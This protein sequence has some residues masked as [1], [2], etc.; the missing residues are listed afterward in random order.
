MA[1]KMLVVTGAGHGIGAMISRCAAKEGYSVSLWDKDLAAAQSVANSIGGTASAVDVDV[2]DEDSV[3]AAFLS[4]PAVPD[5]VVSN[6]GIVRFGPLLQLA[7]SDWEQALRVNLT[8]AFLVGRAAARVMAERA[9]GVIVNIASIN[10]VSAAPFAGG[11]SASKAGIIML[12]QQMA[13]EWAS[14][15][16]RV[17]AVAPGL[18]D[19]G[20]SEPIYED[21]EVRRLR[22]SKVP[23]DRLGSAED[24]AAAVLFLTG[25]T[26]SYI[27]GQTLVVDGGITIAAL[28]QL[29]RPASIDSVGT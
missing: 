18:I 27:T 5:A 3:E 8:G 16:I 15:G 25:S 22:Q 21:V 7:A 6:A 10:G 19:A 12:T 2:T 4:L 9:S 26:A 24:V 29:S 13:L 28:G 20:M 1:A 23:M 11:Y 17:N 14:L